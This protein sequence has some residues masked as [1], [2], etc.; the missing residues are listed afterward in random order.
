MIQGV[1]TTA[2]M[3]TF[4]NN[5]VADTFKGVYEVRAHGVISRPYSKCGPTNDI[6]RAT[7]TVS[8]STSSA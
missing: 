4:Y 3:V 6:T 7:G 5:R 8:T 1:N 2:D